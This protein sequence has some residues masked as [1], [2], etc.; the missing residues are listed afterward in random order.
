MKQASIC[1]CFDAIHFTII[2]YVNFM[3]TLLCEWWASVPPPAP[4]SY[5]C[6][7]LPAYTI[8]FA[9]SLYWS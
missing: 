6:L 7:Q 5:S 2:P 4:A 9:L 1:I 3:R 8:I